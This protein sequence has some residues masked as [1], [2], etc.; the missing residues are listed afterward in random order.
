MDRRGTGRQ[1]YHEE[2]TFQHQAGDRH[3]KLVRDD[4]ELKAPSPLSLHLEA[5]GQVLGAF[6]PVQS[7][8]DRL[9]IHGADC[10]DFQQTR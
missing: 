1:E 2:G 6:Q 3:P 4:L 9:E 7:A 8:F 5:T 10:T